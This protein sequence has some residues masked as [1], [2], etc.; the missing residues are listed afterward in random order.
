MDER[1]LRS[2]MLQKDELTPN[3]GKF[4]WVGKRKGGKNEKRK[5]QPTACSIFAH[6]PLFLP[7]LTLLTFQCHFVVALLKY[8][9]KK[10]LNAPWK[11]L[12]PEVRPKTQNSRHTQH[13]FCARET[14]CFPSPTSSSSF[15]SCSKSTQDGL[16][17]TWVL[18][19]DHA[20]VLRAWEGHDTNGFQVEERRLLRVYR[21]SYSA[22]S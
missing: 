6:S 15:L 21:Q 12:S 2:T 3:D 11:I 18:F 20:P 13:N 14:D 1:T 19:S 8:R 5:S 17:A 4:F 22:Q 9:P 7:K 16:H 10:N